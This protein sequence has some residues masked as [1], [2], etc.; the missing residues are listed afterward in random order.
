MLTPIIEEDYRLY[1]K[2]IAE[3]IRSGNITLCELNASLSCYFCRAHID[4]LPVKLI[5]VEEN[6]SAGRTNDIGLPIHEHCYN[7]ARLGE[8]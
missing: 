1:R 7:E 5:I 8:Y 4:R 6:D 3:K 2:E